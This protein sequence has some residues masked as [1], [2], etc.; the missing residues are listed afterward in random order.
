MQSFRINTSQAISMVEAFVK[1]SDLS[2]TAID[3]SFGGTINK[4]SFFGRPKINNIFKSKFA[5]LIQPPILYNGNMAWFCW[6]DFEISDYPP[7]FL[8]FET[9]DSYEINPT[10]RYPDMRELM[11]PSNVF[12]YAGENLGY[13]LANHMIDKTL[14]VDRVI[15][16]G[17][18]MQLSQ[19]FI[20]R[21]PSDGHGKF[22]KYSFSFFENEKSND[23]QNFLNQPGLEFI[24]YY[25]GFEPK[26]EESNRIRIILVAVD[27]NGR[28]I[29]NDDPATYILQHSWP[30][31]PPIL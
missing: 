1:Q 2:S 9:N 24:R 30:P 5:T 20:D 23:V 13:L 18:V 8:S 19:N 17:E 12:A 28:N 14:Y 27:E 31:P 22:N 29:F 21:G 15:T 26:Y 10:P 6:N 4:I 3:K 7:F 16:R 25:F 11:M